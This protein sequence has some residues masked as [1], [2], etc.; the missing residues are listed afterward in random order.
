MRIPLVYVV[1][2]FGIGGTERHLSLILP[3]LQAR[4]WDVHVA[5]I[6]PDGPFSEPI[7]DAGIEVELISVE[8]PCAGIPKVRAIAM[9]A[10]QTRAVRRCFEQVSPRL[11]HCFLPSPCIV[12]WL[13]RRADHG[14]LIMSR[15]AQRA[16]PEAFLGERTAE[17]RALRRAD[18]VLGHSSQV[19]GELREDGVAADR[20]HHIPNGIDATPYV[21]KKTRQDLRRDYG[22]DENDLVLVCVANLIDYKG[23]DVLIKA[24]ARLPDQKASWRAV[25]IGSGDTQYIDELGRL[26]SSLGIGHRIGFAGRRSD[27][28]GWLQAA[29]VGVLASRHEGFSNAVLEYMAAGLPVVAT[30]VGGNRDAVM[31]GNT[32]LL[33]PAGDVDALAG[34]LLRLADDVSLRRTLGA[35]SAARVETT[36]ALDRI[37]DRYDE[38]YRSLL[39]A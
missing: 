38:L 27:V 5:G 6:G 3:R 24:L 31:H 10:A 19:I 13:A 14:K 22:F 26:A 17:I 1:G 34:A 7:R 16:R 9:L 18:A 37:V 36:Y 23:H 15:R 33:V 12:G 25:F 11:I 2:G 30:D 32:G 39:D 29:D 35:A 21:E 20:L 28:P 8:P 4:G